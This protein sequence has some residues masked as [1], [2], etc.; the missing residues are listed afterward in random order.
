MWQSNQL[1]MDLPSFQ[2]LVVAK[3][4]QKNIRKFQ[5]YTNVVQ[6]NIRSQI[7]R[8][9]QEG[10]AL[11]VLYCLFALCHDGLTKLD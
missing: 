1:K 11:E 10:A 4:H 9:K 6:L 3:I 5:A 2:I 7:E 8:N